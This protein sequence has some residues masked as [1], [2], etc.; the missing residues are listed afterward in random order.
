MDPGSIS[1]FE[2]A[3][4]VCDSTAL[5]VENHLGDVGGAFLPKSYWCPWS[6]RLLREV[7]P[8]KDPVLSVVSSAGLT[9]LAISPGSL[10]SVFGKD[11][12]TR[13]ESATGPD[14]PTKLANVEVE[15]R[16]KGSSSGTKARLLFVSPQQINLVVPDQVSDGLYSVR[17]LQGGRFLEAFTPVESSAPG[18]FYSE[19]DKG[20]FAAATLLRV[21]SDGSR[22]VESLLAVD[23]SGNSVPVPLKMGAPDEKLY[24][25]FYG[26]G[27]RDQEISLF[28]DAKKYPV[29]FSGP[30]GSMPGFEQINVDVPAALQSKAEATILVSV[31]SRDGE[32]LESA[33]VKILGPMTR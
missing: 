8:P 2:T 10:A 11:L 32:T 19:T 17:V 15:F 23:S 21:R 6:S 25:S 16:R 33:P 14:L 3:A 29:L 28:I 20:R 1:F 7:N 31:K 18:L 4:E 9:E 30:Q 24:L 27:V 26:T 13:T 22:S 12:A 5:L